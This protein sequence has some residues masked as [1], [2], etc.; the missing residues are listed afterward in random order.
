MEHT[1]PAEPFPSLAANFLALLADQRPAFRQQRTYQRMCLLVVGFLWSLARHTLTQALLAAGAGD[2]DWSPFYRLFSH[3]RIR[4]THL[5]QRLMRQTFQHVAPSAPYLLAVDGVFLPRSSRR[6]PGVGWRK[7]PNTAPWRPGLALGQRFGALHWLPP[8]TH[9]YTR[10]LPVVSYPIFTPKARPARIA[11]QTE[12]QGA[13]A[14]LT[15]L[16][17]EVDS[18]GRAAQ[19]LVLLADGSYDVA[20]FWKQLPHDTALVA[21]TARN[22]AL[23]EMP[24]AGAAGVQRGRPR[25]YGA[26]VPRPA[27]WLQRR[28]GWQTT[29][30]EVRGHQRSMRYRVEGPFLRSEVAS[31]PVFLVIMGGQSY[32]R[33][34][35]RKHR[36]PAPVLVTAL[37]S[38]DGTWGTALAA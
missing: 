24:E 26:P 35:Q 32:R 14:A 28:S 18:A 13:H 36:E 38:A 6:M 10:A 2:A 3:D 19:R 17:Q 7:A 16:R 33:G 12:W 34:Q 1:T 15:G 5:Q 29:T 37:R 27:E 25:K 23:Y 8:L 20:A 21:R 31:H 11:A 30:R 9:G 22:R 4:M